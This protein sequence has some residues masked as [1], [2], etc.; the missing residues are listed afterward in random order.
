MSNAPHS[1]NRL[2]PVIYRIIIGLGVV[3]ILGIVG[4][5]GGTQAY[6]GLVLMAASLFVVVAIGIPLLLSRIWQRHR[7]GE[8]RP[9]RFRDWLR[10]EV[11]IWQGHLNGGDA[12]AGI[13]LPIT[14]V[15]V[16]MVIFAVVL[17]LIAPA[18]SH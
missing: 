6:N 17:N 15:S 4:F 5:A 16:G 13:L 9:E 11:E 18:G 2:H 8:E 10:D 14:A 3:L 12:I 1:T 7:T